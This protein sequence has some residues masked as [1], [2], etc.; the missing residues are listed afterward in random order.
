MKKKPSK[1]DGNLDEVLSI[2]DAVGTDK[3]T[4]TSV[5][6]EF[7]KTV[8]NPILAGGFAVAFHG[9]VRGTVDV[10]SIGIATISAHVAAF[11]K[12]GYK[13]ETLKLDIG[14]LYLLT[15]GEIEKGIDFIDLDNQEF[16]KSVI[17]R[18]VPGV[19]MSSPVKFVSLEDLI[20]LKML[21][22]IGRKN[23][24]DEIDLEFLLKKPHDKKYVSNWVKKLSG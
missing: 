7:L 8:K 18:A 17:A 24:K 22:K 1:S 4:L 19:F 15:K 10:D 6:A 3:I 20:I 14:T 13:S 21:A 11:K 5:A 2:A 23:K 12:L 9:F 16:K